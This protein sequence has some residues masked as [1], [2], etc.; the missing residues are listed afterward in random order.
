AG[1]LW[2]R[3]PARRHR[4][5]VRELVIPPLLRL[6][7]ETTYHRKPGARFEL[8]RFRRSGI[9]GAFTRAKLEDLF[10]GRY[11]E[12]DFR[13]VEAR[14]HRK[15]KSSGRERRAVFAGLLCD[16]SV[17][18]PFEGAVLLVGDAGT[19]GDWIA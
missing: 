11:R 6:L 12:T 17:P 3:Q 5:A 16:V 8:G 13:L 4:T 18:V 2:S 1:L 10:L 19:R 7:G 9:A 14:L 15:R